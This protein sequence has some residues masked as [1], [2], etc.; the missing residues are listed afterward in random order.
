MNVN[1]K[2]Q[3]P[4]KSSDIVFRHDIEILRGF[5]VLLVLL[6]HFDF[7]IFKSNFVNSG[8]IEVDIFNLFFTHKDYYKDYEFA[9]Y[10]INLIDLN[11]QR[12]NYL[13]NSDLFVNS[14]IILFSQRYRNKNIYSIL[15]LIKITN[16]KGKEIVLIFKKPKFKKNNKLNKTFL[17]QHVNNIN[18]FSKLEL[19]K[20]SFQNLKKDNF[21]NINDKIKEKYSGKIKLINKYPIICS[22]NLKTC[23]IVNGN[24][25]K[26]FYTYCHF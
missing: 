12:L 4:R 20:F 5:S 17:D 1:I 23:E 10:G 19:D 7:N 15:K 6:Y 16:K 14:D 3:D 21:V 26:N 11:N 18:N 9:R 22:Y 24:L 8:Y 13:V 2:S 25:A